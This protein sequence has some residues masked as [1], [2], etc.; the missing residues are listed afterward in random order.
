[1]RN[2]NIVAGLQGVRLQSG[3][4]IQNLQDAV[5]YIKERY[6]EEYPTMEK[7]MKGRYDTEADVDFQGEEERQD[8][9]PRPVSRKSLRAA[10]AKF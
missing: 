8:A 3:R 10:G 6:G 9:S 7:T 4:P 5:E 2:E 1:M